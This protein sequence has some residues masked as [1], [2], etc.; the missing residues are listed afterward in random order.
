MRP[1][2]TDTVTAVR[3]TSESARDRL[4]LAGERLIAEQGP[5]V[6]L[7]AVGAAAGQRNTAAVHYHF[8]SREGL[9]EAIIDRRQA[10]LERRRLHLLADLETADDRDPRTLLDILLRPLFSVPYE[11][12]ST[13]YARF[14]EKVRDHPSMVAIDQHDWPATMLI[15][16][17]IEKSL[18]F[19][20]RLRVARMRALMTIV[21]ALLADLE[22][23]PPPE[24]QRAESEQNVIDVSLGALCAP[25][26][27][28]RTVR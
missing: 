23:D 3:S 6:S 1:C 7:R 19:P 5:S 27:R 12:G 22:R 15:V 28:S 13:H 26:H 16:T 10:S 18:D 8:G 17:R 2:Y 9:I 24:P 4:L 20:R 21:F 14:L 11:E 25:V